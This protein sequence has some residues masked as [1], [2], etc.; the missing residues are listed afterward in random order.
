MVSTAAV[1]RV[2][3]A[4]ALVTLLVLCPGVVSA[5]GAALPSEKAFAGDVTPEALYQRGVDAF[6]AKHYREAA[7]WFVQANAARPDARLYFN[8]GLAFDRAGDTSRALANYRAY[9]SETQ[10]NEHASRISARVDELQ[11]ILAKQGVQQVSI[12]SQPTTVEVAIDGRDWGVTP[13]TGELEP[14]IH[15]VILSRE[16]FE[17]YHL[18][19]SLS[20]T[21]ALTLSATLQRLPDANADRRVSRHPTNANGESW[22]GYR[23]GVPKAPESSDTDHGSALAPWV[24]VGTG[25]AFGLAAFG[26]ELDRRDAAQDAKF[27]TSRPSFEDNVDRMQ[28]SQT[29]ARV[30]ATVAVT[31]VALGVIWLLVSDESPAVNNADVALTQVCGIQ[32]C[33]AGVRF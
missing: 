9:L 22:S 4:G 3:W 16:G 14:G 33:T 23:S 8:I 28:R 15:R 12:R 2:M 1:A 30:F 20:L 31:G 29:F 19:F 6:T 27:A 10:D 7:E 5:E 21:A 24:V 18:E 17:D 13:W 11:K 25:A 32:G 26:F